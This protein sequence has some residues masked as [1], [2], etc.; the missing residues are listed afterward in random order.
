MK[1]LLIL[2]TL[3]TRLYKRYARPT[4][5]EPLGLG[6]LAA[7]LRQQGHEPI[8]L[9]CLAEGWRTQ[10]EQGDLIRF[11]L[12]ETEIERRI[13]QAAPDLI[14]ITCMFSGFDA[15]CRKI[16]AIAKRAMPGKPVIVGGADATAES[17]QLAQDPNID[18][19]VRSEGELTFPALLERL[20]QENALPDDLPGTTLEN[21]VNPDASFVQ[22]LDTL[23]F[24][25]RDLLPMHLYH[26]DQRAIMPYAMRRPIGFMISSRGCPYRC[27]FCSTT[28]VWR[29]WRPRSP[30]NVVDEIAHLTETYGVRE[31]AFLDDSFIADVQRVMDICEQIQSRNIDIAWSVPVGLNVWKVTE[32]ILRA[33]RDT[34][35]YRACFP[36]ESGDPEMLKYMRKPGDLDQVRDTIRSCHKLGIWTYGNFLI[37]FPEQT[38][39][40]IE[41]TIQF[42]ESCGLDMINAYIV[43]PY[44]GAELYDIMDGLGLLH[45]S[46]GAGSTIFE[47]TYD[48]K[49]FTA[50]QLQAKRDELYRRFTKKRIRR[51]L[52]PQGLNDLLRKVSTPKRCAYAIHVF[53]TF[54]KSSL[55]SKKFTIIPE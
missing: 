11:G 32:D 9:D 30:K 55:I 40:S 25:A 18:L 47:T 44:K 54:A 16:A 33:M 27:I 15:D 6:Y 12:S 52:T 41:K 38:P 31:I 28:N 51:L 20:Q 29:Q 19:V 2:P 45:T 36:I 4:M 5:Y 34:G 21:K 42:A 26:E 49:H 23:P 37:G 53:A 48:T 10:E 14:G 8:V 17:E 50:A 24:P 7:V 22:D 43:Q 1:V 13:R 3:T 35:F 39:E 46:H